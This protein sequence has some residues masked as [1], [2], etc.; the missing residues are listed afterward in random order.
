MDFITSK[1]LSAEQGF[2]TPAQTRSAPIKDILLTL[3]AL[4]RQ[5]FKLHVGKPVGLV[6]GLMQLKILES[7]V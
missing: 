7:E 2:V 6:I 5:N 4:T 3:P 1:P